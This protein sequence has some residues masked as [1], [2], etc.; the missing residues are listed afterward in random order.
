MPNPQLL[1]KEATVGFF[2]NIRGVIVFLM[3]SLNTLFWFTP[4]IILALVKLAVPVPAFRRW[5]T[6]I[7][8]AIGD[9]WV[10]VN[11]RIFD[12]GGNIDWQSRGV[13]DLDRGGWYLVIANHQTWVDIVV[14]QT[15]FNRRIPFLKFFIKQQLIWFPVLGLAWWALDMPFMKRYSRAY[16][17][18]NPHK[19]GRDLEAT[20]R[21]CERFKDVPTSVINFVEGTRF[22]DAKRARRGG[23]FTHV[24][25][26][27]AG[28]IAWTL[29]SMGHLFKTLIDA[30]VIYPD[31]PARFWELCCGKRVRAIVEVRTR[32]IPDELLS[33][34]YQNDREFRRR[35]HRWLTAIWQEKDRRLDEHFGASDEAASESPSRD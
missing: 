30:T 12:V 18:K 22:S 26:P 21:A 7:L 9:N 32:P 24:L 27:R 10:A 35:F 3:L 31:G 5:L 20:R 2:S 19:R 8:M 33:G 14:L 1:A 11:A 25:M 29:A 34:D 17:A 28:G 16:L 15:V 6:R 13:E 4:L 23:E